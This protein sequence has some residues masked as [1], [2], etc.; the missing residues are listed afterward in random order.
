M[1]ARYGYDGY[2]LER[3]ILENAAAEE[4]FFKLAFSHPG[5]NGLFL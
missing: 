4:S 1:K 2:V 3:R 5:G